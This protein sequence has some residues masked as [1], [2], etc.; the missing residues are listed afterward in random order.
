MAADFKYR[1]HL[2]V[3]GQPKTMNSVTDREPADFEKYI[4]ER[5]E[6]KTLGY[7]G[8]VTVEKIEPL[9]ESDPIPAGTPGVIT[10][11][12]GNTKK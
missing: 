10:E 8:K 4:K 5:A 3:N 2:K 7:K 12:I 6:K 1:V 11:A 9:K